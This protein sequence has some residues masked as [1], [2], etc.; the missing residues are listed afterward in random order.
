MYKQPI[1]IKRQIQ[2]I[3]DW[4]H[5]MPPQPQTQRS[6]DNDL[7]FDKKIKKKKIMGG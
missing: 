3:N 7:I 5:L 1:K 6:K 4:T 2:N